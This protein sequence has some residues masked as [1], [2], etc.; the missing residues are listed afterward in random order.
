[1]GGE[2]LRVDSGG[3]VR[4]VVMREDVNEE[5]VPCM[6]DQYSRI[7]IRVGYLGMHI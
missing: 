6:G 1:M 2:W 5:V 4:W 3:L 7:W